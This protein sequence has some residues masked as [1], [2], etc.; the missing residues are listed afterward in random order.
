MELYGETMLWAGIA[1]LSVTLILTAVFLA[2]CAV[3]SARLK[4]KLE[5]EYGS[6]KKK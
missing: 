6:K 1:V 2:V 3:S 5:A 4:K